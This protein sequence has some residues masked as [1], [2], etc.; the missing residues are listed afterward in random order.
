MIGTQGG[1]IL[2]KDGKV[3]RGCECCGGLCL[4]FKSEGWSGQIVDLST[5]ALSGTPI[6]G[7]TSH[8]INGDGYGNAVIISGGSVTY[9]PSFSLPLS[10]LWRA[11]NVLTLR[12]DIS[13]S[14]IRAT[15]SVLVSNYTGQIVFESDEVESLV[16]GGVVHLTDVVSNTV[17]GTLDEYDNPMID[18]VGSLYIKRDRVSGC[19]CNCTSNL[20]D[21]SLP[22]DTPETYTLEFTNTS[23]RPDGPRWKSPSTLAQAGKYS[24]FL[25]PG[26]LTYTQTAGIFTNTY[27]VGGCHSFLPRFQSPIVLRKVVGTTAQYMSDP[28]AV[29]PCVKVR[30]YFTACGFPYNSSPLLQAVAVPANA[31][32]TPPSSASFLY[33]P[34]PM[35]IWE[36]ESH[37]QSPSGYKDYIDNFVYNFGGFARVAPGGEYSAEEQLDCG[38]AVANNISLISGCLGVLCTPD[39]IELV[40]TDSGPE[41]NANGT[42]A[43][44]RTGA[45]CSPPAAAANVNFVSGGITTYA[46]TFAISGWNVTFTLVLAPGIES[47][48]DELQPLLRID[49]RPADGSF[50]SFGSTNAGIIPRR[51]DG[52]EAGRYR[53]ACE[54]DPPVESFWENLFLQ[55]NI[56]AAPSAFWK[57]GDISVEF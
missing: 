47:G 25:P 45:S 13:E 38:Q 34:A 12:I 57:I 14:L 40:I 4:S 29:R 31:S 33:T 36:A 35:C 27:A 20:Y 43:L 54:S 50:G 1:K 42:Y 15:F 44:P 7:R 41:L 37:Q 17:P 3:Q 49:M 22:S 51:A 24:N 26:N 48:C 9:A 23:D 30:F 19:N 46:S 21:P 5:A 32:L 52:S 11:P 56:G 39:E 10:Y 28:I 53:S 18:T 8:L 2:L 55:V 6:G 16:A